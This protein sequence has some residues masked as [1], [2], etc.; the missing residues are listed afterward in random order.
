M[1]LMANGKSPG[2]DGFPVEFYKFFWKDLGQYM[3]KSFCYGLS[4]GSLSLT[5]RQGVITCLPKGDKPRQFMKN[6]RPITLLNCD[7]KILSSCIATRLKSILP[8]IIS[9]SQKGFMKGRYIGENTRLVYD[10]MHFLETHQKPGV[11]LLVD[12][13]KAFD[14]IEWSYIQAILKK[15]N[16]GSGI[17]KWIHTL[18]KNPQSTVINNG[19]FS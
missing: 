12:F 3:F 10:L 6:W 14:S 9:D 1:K 18:Y 13:E 17:R 7:Y 11:L 19:H 16:F 5:Q 4:S 8:K 15:Y 2:P